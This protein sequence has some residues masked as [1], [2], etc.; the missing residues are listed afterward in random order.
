VVAIPQI[1]HTALYSRGVPVYWKQKYASRNQ[2]HRAWVREQARREAA[3][4]GAPSLWQWL[5]ARF[6]R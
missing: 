4:R 1:P 6:G 3:A 2:R 5:R